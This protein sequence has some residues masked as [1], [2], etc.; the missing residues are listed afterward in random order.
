[1]E[2]RPA[3]TIITGANMAGKSTFLRTISVNLLLAM[4]GAP[5]CAREM[6][7]TPCN[8]MSSIKIQD[9]L[10]ENASY[11]YA[12]LV[13]LREI[14]EQ[15]Q[16]QPKTLVVLDEILRGTNTRDKQAGS[17][18]FLEKLISLN[19]I[20]IIATHDLKIGELENT[21]PGKVKN[22]CFEV[23]LNKDQLVFDY[24]LK[25]GISQKLNASFLMKKMG[26]I[27]GD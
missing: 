18:G 27:K 5:V 8:I 3:I 26:I 13:R 16:S 15:I 6:K 12:E 7:Y 25:D 21:H 19:A 23:E 10:V 17:L 1:L 20:V 2:G 4:N 11:F 9:S 14:I 24:K 22:Q